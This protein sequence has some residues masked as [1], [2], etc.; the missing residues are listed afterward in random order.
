MQNSLSSG[1]AMTTPAEA[2]FF[3]DAGLQPPGAE[4]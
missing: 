2:V 3:C 4:R 1:L